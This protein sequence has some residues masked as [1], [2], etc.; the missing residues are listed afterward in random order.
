[1]PMPC[2]YQILHRVR[3]LKNGEKPDTGNPGKSKS[4]KD[5]AEKL[6]EAEKKLKEARKSGNQEKVNRLREIVNN[7]EQTIVRG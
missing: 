7:L 5:L 1:M 3:V 2:K 6:A 4:S